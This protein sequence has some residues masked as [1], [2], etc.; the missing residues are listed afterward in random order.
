MKERCHNPNATNWK[1][2]GGRGIEVYPEWRSDYVAF[3]A[4]MEANLGERPEG[5]SLDRIDNDG[6]YEPGN[7]RWATRREQALN[8]RTVHGLE[9]RLAVALARIAELEEVLLKRA[10][11]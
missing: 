8:R 4:W 7:L 3:R 10:A 9:E 6:N 11:L 2:Y 5:M 1:D